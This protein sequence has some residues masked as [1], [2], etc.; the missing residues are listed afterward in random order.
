MAANL[1]EMSSRRSYN[2]AAD[3]TGD[4]RGPKENGEQLIFIKDPFS[5]SGID[6]DASPPLLWRSKRGDLHGRPDWLDAFFHFPRCSS[7]LGLSTDS[8]EAQWA[9]HMTSDISPFYPRR[10]LGQCMGVPPPIT[11]HE[12]QVSFQDLFQDLRTSTCTPGGWAPSLRCHGCKCNANF[13]TH[14]APQHCY[15]SADS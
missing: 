10:R 14:I 15:R 3:T 11:A 4:V 13:L 12:V 8:W 2:S 1:P 5:S 6:C 9:K 7:A